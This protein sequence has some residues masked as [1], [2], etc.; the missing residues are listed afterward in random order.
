MRRCMLY[1]VGSGKTSK[2]ERCVMIKAGAVFTDKL[3]PSIN[4]FDK[5][6]KD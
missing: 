1:S 5:L 2:A 4:A 6:L 3:Y